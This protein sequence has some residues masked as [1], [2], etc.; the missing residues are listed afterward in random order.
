[1]TDIANVVTHPIGGVMSDGFSLTP[2]GVLGGG[3][4]HPRSYGAFPRFLRRFVRENALLSWEAAI[5]KLTGYA[6]SR[7]RITERGLVREG[8]FADVLVFD[9]DGIMD[10]ASFDDPYRFPTGIDAIL[11]NGKIAA[12]TG[13]QS[14]LLSG[15]ILRAGRS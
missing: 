4:H 11:V 7:F 3:K 5:H 10:L 6:A 14:D 15:R 1:E 9:K 2:E 13:V 12:Q 8:C